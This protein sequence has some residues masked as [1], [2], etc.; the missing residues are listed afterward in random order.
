MWPLVREGDRVRL[1]PGIPLEVGQLAATLRRGHLVV[2]RIVALR[3]GS[4]VL[5]GDNR[6]TDD[7]PVAPEEVL[8]VV[9]RQWLRSGRS[10]NLGGFAGRRLGRAAA[11]GSRAFRLPWQVAGLAARAW[12]ALRR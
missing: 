4:V 3:P 1:E 7:A 9:T 2:H 10:V 5:R 6:S 11:F 8:G 12:G